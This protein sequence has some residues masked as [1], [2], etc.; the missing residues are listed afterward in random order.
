[1]KKLIVT[2]IIAVFA[3]SLNAQSFIGE[4]Q[5]SVLLKIQYNN[6]YEELQTQ[7]NFVNENNILMSSMMFMYRD[8][9]FRYGL[10]F[11]K[12]DKMMVCVQEYHLFDYKDLYNAHLNEVMA[13]SQ[14]RATPGGDVHI[15]YKNYR[16]ILIEYYYDKRFD[17][18]LI[19]YK[20]NDYVKY[21][22]EQ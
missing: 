7:L 19:I 2:I 15:M 6:K 5:D 18:Y 4:Q 13:T 16:E 14:L 22:K 9:G 12:K 21:E 10:Y 8:G 1:M 17:K 11:V 3:L 20:D